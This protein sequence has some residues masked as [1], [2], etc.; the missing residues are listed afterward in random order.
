MWIPKNG[1]PRYDVAEV[2]GFKIPKI[3]KSTGIED[4]I[5][6]DFWY[7]GTVKFYPDANG[8]CWGFTYDIPENRKLLYNSFRSGWFKIVNNN[9]R[10]EIK[11][12]AEELGINTSRAIR[13][14]V[15]VK[16][17]AKER[18]AEQAI[19]VKER[20]IEELMAKMADL[21]KELDVV[22]NIK[23]VSIEERVAGTPTPDPEVVMAK[24]PAKPIG[25]KKPMTID[26]KI[27]I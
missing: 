19:A 23:Q 12:E 1:Q 2:N 8:R 20:K 10:E 5:R 4:T 18:D 9:L 22:K 3:G 26:S 27:R 11:K 6:A 13:T 21:K 7:D 14:E 17:T 15:N 24:E 25:S 16:K